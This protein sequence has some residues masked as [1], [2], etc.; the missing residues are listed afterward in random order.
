MITIAPFDH[1]LHYALARALWERT[2]GVGL[3]DADESPAIARFLDRNPG[4]SLVACAQERLVGTVLVG[5]DGRRGLIHHLAVDD[6]ARRRGIGR[7]LVESALRGLA[8]AGIAKCHLLVF[9]DNAAGR[10]FWAAVGATSRDDLAIC[11][12]A[13]A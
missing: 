8:S 9:A 13:T 4:L 7:C 11:S 3:G 12:L 1:R 10:A 5:H 6:G 2:P